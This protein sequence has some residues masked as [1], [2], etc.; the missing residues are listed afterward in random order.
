MSCELCSLC[1][2]G[3]LLDFSCASATH[4][5]RCKLSTARKTWCHNKQVHTKPK[6]KEASHLTRLSDLLFILLNNPNSATY[7]IYGFSLVPF[8]K[9]KLLNSLSINKE[10][11]EKWRRWLLLSSSTQQHFP[12]HIVIHLH[13]P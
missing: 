10:R 7:W 3:N 9:K 12:L 4:G 8:L 5:I 13:H 11:K 2:T 1:G 6:N